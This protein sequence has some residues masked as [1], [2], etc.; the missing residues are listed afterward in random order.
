MT[1]VK[2][3]ADEQTDIQTDRT[4]TICHPPTP[5]IWTGHKNRVI[6][7]LLTC[8]KLISLVTD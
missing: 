6:F 5:D 3:L 1:N 8:Q 7:Q 2:V 4:K